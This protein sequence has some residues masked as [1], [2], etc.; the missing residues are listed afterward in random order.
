[1]LDYQ[2]HV[3]G[4]RSRARHLEELAGWLTLRMPGWWAELDRRDQVWAGKT[5]EPPEASRL[6]TVLA[7]VH[8]EVPKPK[9]A[10]W[11]STL[12][13]PYLSPWLEW[14]EGQHYG[15]MTLWRLVV[16]A[17]ARVAEIHSPQDWLSLCVRYPND[18]PGSVF[19]RFDP[20]ASELR[21]DPDWSKVAEDWDGV[22]L[23]VGGWLTAED[24]PCPRKGLA[25]ELRG[26]NM[27][28]SVW[29][30]WVFSSSKPMPALGAT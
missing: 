23:S 19:T 17:D 26:W 25:T 9:E 10:L 22:H 7:Q 27:E 11:T 16:A 21:L 18:V 13:A 20:A 29:L 1:M 4:L 3:A 30:R 2:A 5:S 12:I 14:P 6:T 8:A 15:P 24:V 28:S